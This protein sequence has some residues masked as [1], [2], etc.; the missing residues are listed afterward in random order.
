MNGCTVPA[1]MRAIKRIDREEPNHFF[2]QI[3]EHLSYQSIKKNVLLYE[4]GRIGQ[5]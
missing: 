5:L 3:L 4:C 1:E 2:R